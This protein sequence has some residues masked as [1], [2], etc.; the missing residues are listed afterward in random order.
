MNNEN[1]YPELNSD[2]IVFLFINA[3]FHLLNIPICVVKF[4]ILRH[5]QLVPSFHK[6]ITQTTQ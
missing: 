3:V 6:N 1:Y 2:N 5:Q 4:C